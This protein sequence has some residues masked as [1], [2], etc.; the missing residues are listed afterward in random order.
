MFIP[1]MDLCECGASYEKRAANQKWCA[2]CAKARRSLGNAEY[3]RRMRM[4][5]TPAAARCLDLHS[6]ALTIEQRIEL[7]G[8]AADTFS[9]YSPRN[10]GIFVARLMEM[11]R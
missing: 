8:K 3:M 4:N 10:P 11:E 6:A 1:K 9:D 7:I 2:A 5:E